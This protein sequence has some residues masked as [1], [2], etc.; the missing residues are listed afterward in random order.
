M[1]TFEETS[2]RECTDFVESCA[3]AMVTENVTRRAY[4]LHRRS[5]VEAE[6]PRTGLACTCIYALMK[7][8]L[9]PKTPAWHVLK[10]GAFS[11][12]SVL[13]NP[14]LLRWSLPIGDSI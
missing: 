8:V 5:N 4:E 2:A 10:F 13:R 3:L 6:A 7:I 11:S 12:L 14:I 9:N 1:R